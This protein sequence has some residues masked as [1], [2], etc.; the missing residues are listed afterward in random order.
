MSYYMHSLPGRLRLKSPIAKRNNGAALEIKKILSSIYG[1][2]T[3]DINPTTGSILINYNHKTVKH[4]DIVELLQR[5]GYF[6]ASSA[7]TNDQ[8]IKRSASNA[9]NALG[10]VVLGTFF[11]KAFEGSALSLLGLL[12]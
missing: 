1:I 6:D 5:K 3:V 9:G 11:E 10:K 8:Y 4:N 2:A 7:L 12:I